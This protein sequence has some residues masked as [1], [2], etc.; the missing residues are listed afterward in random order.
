MRTAASMLFGRPKPFIRPRTAALFLTVVLLP[1]VLFSAGPAASYDRKFV[2][3][4]DGYYARSAE[5]GTYII[6][7]ADRG[8]RLAAEIE[9][10]ACRSAGEIAAGIGLE[11]ISPVAII[12]APDTPSFRRLH[13]GQLPEWGEAFGDSRRMIIGIDASRVLFSGR[14]LETVVRHELSHVLLA[15]R[16]AGAH[17]PSWFVEGIAMR[18]SREWTLRDQWHLA[19]TVWRE[20][21]PRL[22]D[23]RGRFPK[24]AGKAAMAYRVSYAAV[25]ELLAGG[26]RDLITF[27]AFL[28][29]TG[30]FEK[31]FTLTFGEMVGEFS[32]RFA[33]TMRSRYRKTA[34][35]LSIS[36]Y[37]LT[38]SVMFLL[39]YFIKRSRSRRRI[40]QWE[41]EDTEPPMLH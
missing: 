19:L 5:C 31:A 39:A 36:P 28:R 30:D 8:E 21:M 17:C 38:L 3:D 7:Y 20:D 9:K 16:T 15:Q 12:I 25:N 37:G 35:F 40:E 11:D 10:M 24:S 34:L 1:A 6:Y 32:G 22:E 18:Q 14:P 27:T 13:G 23:L 4:L 41:S 33:A 26:E 2:E 29:D